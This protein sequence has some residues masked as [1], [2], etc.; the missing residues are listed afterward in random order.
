MFRWL[1]GPWKF[2]ACAR[3]SRS[4]PR[5]ILI[6]N[7][8]ENTFIGPYLNDCYELNVGD[9]AGPAD[10]VC[11]QKAWLLLACV[12]DLTSGH[13]LCQAKPRHGA[14]PRD[15]RIRILAPRLFGG[16][17]DARSICS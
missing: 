6:A 4:P 11:K 3:S 2:F 1:P 14:R 9:P 10:G 5:I 12:S 13:H 8:A 7:K 15:F 16:F 17:L